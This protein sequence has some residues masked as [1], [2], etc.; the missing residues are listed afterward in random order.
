[1][2]SRANFDQQN[3][4]FDKT[5]AAIL[6]TM[7]EPGPFPTLE[8]ERLVLREI[9][10]DDAE[11]LFAIHGNAEAMRWFGNDPMPTIEA[12]HETIAAFDGWRRTPNPG[13]RWCVQLK[14]APDLIGTCGLFKWNRNWR[15]CDIG[16]ELSVTHQGNGY[17][18]EAVSRII[19]WGFEAMQLNRIEAGIHPDNAASLTLA[20]RLG[21]VE[22]GRLREA[23][24]WNGQ[25][26]DLLQFSL[27]RSDHNRETATQRRGG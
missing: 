2:P 25:F 23:G 14:S 11:A 12:A 17:M 24:Y 16:Y 15:T 13:H 21:F 20:K 26:Q 5:S 18:A 7:S 3:R 6:H 1:M 19:D 22:E 27:L 8:T 9:T 10:P 4:P